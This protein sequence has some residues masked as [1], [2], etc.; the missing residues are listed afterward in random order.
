MRAVRCGLMLCVVL[1]A[2]SCLSTPKA[3]KVV[4]AD[5]A[6]IDEGCDPLLRNID[7]TTPAVTECRKLL[8]RPWFGKGIP[9][10]WEDAVASLNVREKRGLVFVMS[11]R[12]SWHH[13]QDAINLVG[14][15]IPPG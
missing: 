1:P 9:H 11:Q 4:T 14:D 3:T 15:E 6:A 10:E 13:W 7:A 5:I 2:I 12:T 8:E